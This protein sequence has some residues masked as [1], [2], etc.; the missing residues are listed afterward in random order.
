MTESISAIDEHGK[1]VQA[2][3]SDIAPG[4]DRANRIMSMGTD[5]RWRRRA[6][7]GLLARGPDH[8]HVLDLCA[9]TLDASMEVL[10]HYPNATVTAGDFS[11]G[12]LAAGRCGCQLLSRHRHSVPRGAKVRGN[13]SERPVL[14]SRQRQQPLHS[15]PR[16]PGIPRGSCPLR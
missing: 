9:G 15:R 13:P 11:A 16:R 1:R 12:M 7:R 10:H 4:Y 5:V 2:M 8:A 14:A 6:I 3:F